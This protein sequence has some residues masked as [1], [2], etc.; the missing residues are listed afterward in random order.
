MAFDREPSRRPVAIGNLH[1]LI[2]QITDEAGKVVQEQADYT[3]EII[4][5]DGS[6]KLRQGELTA[7]L[8]AEQSRRMQQFV[9]E[10]R[11]KAVNEI[12]PV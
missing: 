12:L 2:T 5:D 1:V 9:A 8:S 7:H 11:Q 10:V 6:R 3:L 4:F